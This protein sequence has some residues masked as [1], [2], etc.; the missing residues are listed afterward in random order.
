MSDPVYLDYNSTTPIDPQV[1]KFIEP[2]YFTTFGNAASIT[3]K[4]G[5]DAKKLV[6]HSRAQIANGLNVRSDEI[7][8]TSGATE[9]INMAIKGVVSASKQETKHIITVKTEHKA[10]LDTCDY[11][12]ELGAEI[13][14]IATD[15]S[16]H[17]A[18]DDL[19]SA[20]RADTV[21][22]IIMHGNNEIGTMHPIDEIGKLCKQHDILVL[23]DAAQT[24]GKVPIDLKNSGVALLAGS[25]HKIYGPKGIGF[26]Y[27]DRS[28]R[29]DPLIHGG[30]HEMGLR[31][32]THN[33]AGIVGLA[34]AYQLMLNNQAEEIRMLDNYKKL[35]LQE[36]KKSDIAF[37]INGCM[38]KRIPGNLNICFKKI[39]ADWLTTML[40]DIAI[41]RGSACTSETIQPSHVLRAIG[42][43]D[44]DAYGSVRISFGRFTT[45]SEVKKAAEL[46][47]KQ[48]KVFQSK[49][50]VLAI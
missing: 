4:F 11:L 3:H 13:D 38:K 28:V 14:F 44:E 40:P 32:G 6:D 41:A 42:L 26:L 47:V 10:V 24:F 45:S 27:K 25:G 5:K 50:E 17:I 31:S 2:L 1:S 48:V 22:V 34:T 29:M 18:L 8:F 35:F 19:Q 30:G 36:L 20:I 7:I 15:S 43:S 33:V 39:D 21:L 12:K 37:S 49:K 46:I 9:A 23:V 16:G